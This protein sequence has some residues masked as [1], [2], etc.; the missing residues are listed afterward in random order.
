VRI[1]LRLCLCL[2]RV[3]LSLLLLLLL[4]FLLLLLRVLVHVEQ[5]LMRTLLLVGALL[6]ACLVQIL[7][8]VLPCL[9]LQ[10]LHLLLVAAVQRSGSRVNSIQ[11]MVTGRALPPPA[12]EPTCK[13]ARL[14][15]DV[16]CV[17]HTH[18]LAACVYVSPTSVTG[19]PQHGVHRPTPCTR[20]CLHLSLCAALLLV[21]V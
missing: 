8:E 18:L 7:L 19:S 2:C 15:E 11:C 1:Y 3:V 20:R 6:V 4:L 5:V 10:L 14:H 16:T 13:A 9:P 12:H 17:C 21:E